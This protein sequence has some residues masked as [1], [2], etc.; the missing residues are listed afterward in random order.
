MSLWPLDQI[1]ND[2]QYYV[3]D[4]VID[5]ITA[6]GTVSPAI[7]GRLLFGDTVAPVVTIT[8]PTAMAY[9]H[10]SFLTLDFSA[11]DGADGTTPSSPLRR[12]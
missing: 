1:V 6:M 2:T 3:R 4:A 9:T 7:E 11:V 12:A 5:Y 8:A 10:S